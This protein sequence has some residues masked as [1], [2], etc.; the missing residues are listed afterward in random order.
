MSRTQLNRM[1]GLGVASLL[2]WGPAAPV[3][4]LPT[5][6]S[7]TESLH[8]TSSYGS[9]VYDGS[10]PLP[11]VLTDAPAA[12]DDSSTAD[13]S[14]G[15]TDRDGRRQRLMDVAAR[16]GEATYIPYV[17]GG[18][19]IG[20]ADT[21]NACRSCIASKPK[22]P[23]ARRRAACEPCRSCGID[24]SHF[25]NK[26]YNEAGLSFPYAATA[27]LRRLPQAKL[28]EKYSLVDIGPQ[29]TKAQ[30]GDLL[31]MR[32]HI[33][34]LLKMRTG[35]R[36][37]I[38]H[39]SRSVKKGGRSKIGGVEVREDV[40]LTRFHGKIVKILRHRDLDAPA[41]YV[42]HPPDHLHLATI[43]GKPNLAPTVEALLFNALPRV[44]RGDLVGP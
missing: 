40:D 39:V 22:L 24:C 30:P 6:T 8:K 31:L 41:R 7:T 9:P 44:A 32:R 16:M 11:A 5:G 2:S 10:A 4:A 21:C 43:G 20:N 38:L 12:S 36:G 34:M 25:V 27:A 23:I 19:A 28:K 26:I 37:D 35:K 33:V 14:S 1:L 29:L 3:K 18:R 15:T 13:A 42:P 17:W